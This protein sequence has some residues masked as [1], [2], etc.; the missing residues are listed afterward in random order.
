[1]QRLDH[2]AQRLH[3]RL[4]DRHRIRSLVVD[5]GVGQQRDEAPGGQELAQ[6]VVVQVA[7]AVAVHQH[8]QGP[9]PLNARPTVAA[10]EGRVVQPR[11]VALQVNVARGV[12]PRGVHRGA[13]LAAGRGGRAVAGDHP[14]SALLEL[15][16]GGQL[17]ACVG[18]DL[19]RALE[20]GCHRHQQPGVVQQRRI[21]ADLHAADAHRGRGEEDI[22]P[23]D[24]AVQDQHVAG[25]HLERVERKQRGA[26]GDPVAARLAAAQGQ[27]ADV[28]GG[29][30]GRPATAA[31]EAAVA[32][33][34]LGVGLDAAVVGRGALVR[35]GQVGAWLT[36]IEGRIGCWVALIR[37][38]GPIIAAGQQQ[39]SD[40]EQ[41]CPAHDSLAHNHLLTTRR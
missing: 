18:G 24:R 4:T 3:L 28:T 32:W 38:H 31:V 14:G 9:G 29:L 35:S 36:S 34:W 13:G 27:V 8:H 7:G 39:H 37:G 23:Q 1:M 15:Q 22:A 40:G 21:G 20:P 41:V 25:R 2:D 30:A 6:V 10:A 33:R 17:L 5:L 16:L 12:G 26:R 11:H 19:H